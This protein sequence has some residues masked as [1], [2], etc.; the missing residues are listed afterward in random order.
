MYINEKTLF[1]NLSIPNLNL[2]Y[3]ERLKNG[4]CRPAIFLEIL[5]LLKPEIFVGLFLV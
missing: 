3:N 4:F 5:N 1:K 2:G